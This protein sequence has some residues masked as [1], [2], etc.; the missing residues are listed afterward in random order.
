MAVTHLP[1]EQTILLIEA[2][3]PTASPRMLFDYWTQ[4]SL[5]EQWWP[6][7]A[8]LVGKIGGRYHLSWPQMNW[9]LRGH[10]TSFEPGKQLGF[11]W[12]WDHDEPEADEREVRLVLMPSATT[13]TLLHLTHAFYRDTPEDQELRIEHHLAGWLHF[14]SR[15]QQLAAS[16]I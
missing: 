4:P 15:L 10:Y 3:F 8:E 9:H 6:Q 13:G 16:P 2:D 14:L 11:T 7:K 1:S 5:L 12:K